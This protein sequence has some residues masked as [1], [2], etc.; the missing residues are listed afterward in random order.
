MDLTKTPRVQQMEKSLWDFMD[1]HVFPAEPLAARQVAESGSA[2]TVPAVLAELRAEARRRGLWNLFLSAKHGGSGLTNLEYAY[3]AEISGWSDLAPVAM[4]CS[5]PD[6]GNMEILAMFG[7]EEQKERWLR[8]LLDA[9]IRSCFSMT[10]PAVAS[11]D[12]TNIATTLTVDGDEVVINGRKWFTSGAASTMCKLAIV[13]ARNGAP[14]VR[15]HESHTMVLVPLDTPGVRVVRAIPVFGY[16]EGHGHCEVVYEDVRV[17]LSNVLG[18]VGEGFAIAQARLGPGRVHHCMRAIG[19]SEHALSLMVAR[20][21]QRVAW[22][23]PLADQGV[24]QQWIARSR[25]EIDQARMLV[26]KAAWTMDTVGNK[27]AAQAIS[28]IKVIAAE[29]ACRVVDRA[30]QAHGA[31]GVTPDTPLA[32]MSAKARTLRIADGPDEVHLRKVAR[33][34]LSRERRLESA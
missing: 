23:R 14:G 5:S 19:M 22:G 1:N 8:P 4:N 16:E 11:S 10:E 21:Q 17:P 9:E 27:D 12:A 18:G 32:A 30:I 34:E 2:H 6:T 20:V 25:L 7:T 26:L 28:A 24:V 3:L 31:A 15:S 29:V 33:I 13:M